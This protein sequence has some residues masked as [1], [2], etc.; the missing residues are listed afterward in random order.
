MSTT[1]HFHD[2]IHA[3]T[4]LRLCGLLRR[5]E[6]LEFSAIRDALG[7]RDANVSNNLAVLADAGLVS[8]RKEASEKRSDARR[9]TWVALTDSGR[10]AVQ[11]HLAALRAIAEL[12][13]QPQPCAS[14]GSRITAAIIVGR[15]RSRRRPALR[16]TRRRAS[17]VAHRNASRPRRSQRLRRAGDARDRLGDGTRPAASRRHGRVGACPRPACGVRGR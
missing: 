3:P 16:R 11:E 2:V 12:T 15:A 13:G 4:R 5:V 8:M 6:E 17:D 14:A 7:L 10:E 9:L 1:A